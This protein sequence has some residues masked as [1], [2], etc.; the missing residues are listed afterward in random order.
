MIVRQLTRLPI[1][2]QYAVTLYLKLLT[3]V[4]D[5]LLVL[6]GALGERHIVYQWEDA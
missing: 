5:L 3:S 6:K 2:T 1:D 4:D